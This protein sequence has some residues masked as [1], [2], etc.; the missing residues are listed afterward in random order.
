MSP[1]DDVVVAFDGTEYPG[2]LLKLEGSGYVLCKIHPDP[3]MDH[4]PGTAKMAPEQVVAVRMGAVR[5]A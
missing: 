2:E 1:G 3:L 4:G 5:K